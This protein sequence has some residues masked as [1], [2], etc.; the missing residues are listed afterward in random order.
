MSCLQNV[1]CT[2]NNPVVSLTERVSLE[3]TADMNSESNPKQ[4]HPL[5]LLGFDI[6]AVPQSALQK[7]DHFDGIWESQV[8]NTI[9]LPKLLTVDEMKEKARKNATRAS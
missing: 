9:Y 8:K 6:R 2:D 7:H 3:A 1:T 4:P 5:E